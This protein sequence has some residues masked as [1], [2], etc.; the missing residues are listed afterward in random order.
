MPYYLTLQLRQNCDCPSITFSDYNENEEAHYF[1]PQNGVF[2]IVSESE[3][4]PNKVNRQVVLR[5]PIYWRYLG[6]TTITLGGDYNWF[7][8]FLIPLIAFA[9]RF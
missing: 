6:D 9:Y 2:E 1:A 3:N 5:Q 4:S 7:V 8:E